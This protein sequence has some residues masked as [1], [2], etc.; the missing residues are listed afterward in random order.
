MATMELNWS[1]CEI[2]KCSFQYIFTDVITISKSVYKSCDILTGSLQRKKKKIL[3]RTRLVMSVAL[4]KSRKARIKHW[5]LRGLMLNALH[6]YSSS[7][8]SFFLNIMH[9]IL[10][11]SFAE[12]PIWFCFCSKKDTWQFRDFISIICHESGG[13]DGSTAKTKMSQSRQ[14][15]LSKVQTLSQQL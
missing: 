9:T 1:F 6:L 5:R 12:V 14:E 15:M 10:S 7:V 13:A 11:L 8:M 3:F 4:D 2:I